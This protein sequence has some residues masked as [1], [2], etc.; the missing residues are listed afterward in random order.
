MLS[1][2]KNFELLVIQ[3]H[4]KTEELLEFK[5]IQPK[6]TFSFESSLNLCLDNKWMVGLTKV[7][8]YNSIS[9][10]REEKTKF[11]FYTVSSDDEVFWLKRKTR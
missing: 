8:V 1:T 6:D 5:L 2:T 4:T 10:I 11:V 7:E 3:T 9:N